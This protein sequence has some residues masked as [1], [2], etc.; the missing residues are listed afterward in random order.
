MSCVSQ[1]IVPVPASILGGYDMTVNVTVLLEVEG[2]D[3]SF[4]QELAS[5]LNSQAGVETLAPA[6][7]GAD[8]V[9]G[10]LIG[11]AVDAFWTAATYVIQRLRGRDI[12]V[13]FIS[14]RT[15]R[16]QVPIT[17]QEDTDIAVVAGDFAFLRESELNVDDDSQ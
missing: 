15:V 13:I 5:D 10:L 16:Q 11:L 1:V 17:S 3:T 14:T 7:R 8:V 2:V 4:W 9:S 12:Q 6:P